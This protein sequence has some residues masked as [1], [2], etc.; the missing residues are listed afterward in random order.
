MSIFTS[1]TT[2]QIE[3]ILANYRLSPLAHFMPISGGTQNT[4]YLLT[5]AEEQVV[6]TI[7]EREDGAMIGPILT[8]IDYLAEH[9]FPCSAI[10]PNKSG[11]WYQLLQEK[12]VFIG[13]FIVGHHYTQLTVAQSQQWGHC[14]AQFHALTRTYPLFRKQVRDMSWIQ[15]MSQQ[16]LAKLTEREQILLSDEC[17]FQQAQDYS[18]L[19]T[20][21]IHADLFLDNV[22]FIEDTIA[23]IVD[24]YDVSQGPQLLDVAIAINDS[25]HDADYQIDHTLQQAFFRGYQQIRPLTPPEQRAWPA[26][27]RLAALTFWLLR[28]QRVHFPRPSAGVTMKDPTAYQ[29]L[30]Q[31]LRDQ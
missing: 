31:G 1:L 12:P 24:F 16:V 25:C 26:M 21:V 29:N 6:L 30:L 7:Y 5:L 10:I 19:P 11:Q 17:G 4:N 8:F 3:T 20:G 2:Q 18:V 27:Q 14:L 15:Q 13:K 28:L 22:L 9:Q 23:G